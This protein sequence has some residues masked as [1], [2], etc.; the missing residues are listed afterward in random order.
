MLHL[1]KIFL[2]FSCFCRVT[3]M[4]SAWISQHLRWRKWGWHV[5]SRGK[6]EGMASLQRQTARAALR[7]VQSILAPRCWDPPTSPFNIPGSCSPRGELWKQLQFKLPEGSA[8][9]ML[10]E[11]HSL[12]QDR[13]WSARCWLLTPYPLQRCRDLGCNFA[14]HVGWNQQKS[15]TAAGQKLSFLS[16]RPAWAVWGHKPGCFLFGFWVLP[17]S[18]YSSYSLLCLAP[19]PFSHPE[20]CMLNAVGIEKTITKLILFLFTQSMF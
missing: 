17:R 2:Q 16:A 1:H 15:I 13:L 20:M 18:F 10:W 6:G 11:S 4:L 5:G 3:P 12:L 7:W 8:W 9:Q 19:W 14:K